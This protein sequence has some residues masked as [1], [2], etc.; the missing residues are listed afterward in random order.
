M[1]DI[2]AKLKAR[3]G[4]DI[5]FILTEIGGFEKDNDLDRVSVM[6]QQYTEYLAVGV[7][8]V[9]WCWFGPWQ[10]GDSSGDS[11][12]TDGNFVSPLAHFPSPLFFTHYQMSQL[13]GGFKPA[14]AIKA[15]DKVKAYLFNKGERM[16]LALW[17]EKGAVLPLGLTLPAQEVEYADV[18]GRRERLASLDGRFHVAVD[19]APVFLF[20]NGSSAGVSCDEEPWMLELKNPLLVRGAENRL[21]VAVKTPSARLLSLSR[22]PGQRG[23]SLS[24]ALGAYEPLARHVI[25]LAL[26]R[27]GAVLGIA[28]CPV[29]VCDPITLNITTGS[30]APVVTV[31]NGSAV[32]RRGKLTLLSEFTG[33]LH[34][35]RSELPV[36]LAAHDKA[37]FPVPVEAGRP[38][39]LPG[40]VWASLALEGGKSFREERCLTLLAAP[41]TGG[42]EAAT[43]IPLRGGTGEHWG[44][45]TY[46]GAARGGAWMGDND[47]SAEF[48]LRWDDEFLHILADV[49][50]DDF[51]NRNVDGML[52]NGDAI[53]VVVETRGSGG[54]PKSFYKILAAL[55]AKGPQALFRFGI[56][57]IVDLVPL[58]GKVQVER[59]DGGLRYELAVPWKL[60]KTVPKPGMELGVSFAVSDDDGAG[61]CQFLQRYGT[62]TDP[63]YNRWLFASLLLEP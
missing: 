5:P 56:S 19:E 22:L 4:R 33:G 21:E 8:M 55:T 47:L 46:N 6:A 41:R 49:K 23:D 24:L 62:I 48:R 10:V 31:E 37:K 3:T 32:A 11:P 14:D 35:L 44:P 57:N 59:R 34:P 58:G 12:Y 50:D 2:R 53:E 38:P 15:P 51:C 28:A 60:L 42:W 54:E 61:R 18:A 27:N 52:W 9:M 29:V 17:S 40:R 45:R 30:G 26:E 20:W 1:A 43:P 25:P 63:R 13:L 39:E 36:E 16:A 7:K